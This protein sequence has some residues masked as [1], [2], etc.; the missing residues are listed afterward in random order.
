MTN[1]R[2]H[3]EITLAV[4]AG[5]VMSA[6]GASQPLTRELTP[7]RTSADGK[8]PLDRAIYVEDATGEYYTLKSGA[9]VMDGTIEILN[10][11]QFLNEA[12]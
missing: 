1:R 4:Q 7:V 3:Y 2:G 8:T 5:D 12:A 6:W 9:A 10:D 11:N